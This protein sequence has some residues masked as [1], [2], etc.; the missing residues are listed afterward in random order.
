MQTHRSFTRGSA[1]EVLV[2]ISNARPAKMPDAF[3]R[4]RAARVI[5][6]CELLNIYGPAPLVKSVVVHTLPRYLQRTECS[7]PNRDA[8]G[9]F[10]DCGC[11]GSQSKKVPIDDVKSMPRMAPVTCVECQIAE[12]NRGTKLYDESRNETTKRNHVTT[13]V[14][15]T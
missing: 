11:L 10:L 9:M 3:G 14:R 13:R 4:P 7:V 8:A 6:T 2:R 12:R 1:A 5:Y 15:I